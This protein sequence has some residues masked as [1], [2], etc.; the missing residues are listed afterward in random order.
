MNR[1]D[2]TTV[3]TTDDLYC[4]IATDPDVVYK[5]LA[6]AVQRVANV[7]NGAKQAVGH[8]IQGTADTMKGLFHDLLQGPL[9][10]ILYLAIVLIVIAGLLGVGFI[11]FLRITQWKR[12][13]SYQPSNTY[14]TASLAETDNDIETQ[15]QN[16]IKCQAWTPLNRI[17]G[18]KFTQTDINNPKHNYLLLHKCPQFQDNPHAALKNSA[19]G[20]WCSTK[21]MELKPNDASW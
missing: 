17:I 8:L 4:S 16:N 15:N 11:T 9:K 6:G 10:V 3:G 20:I 13:P 21:S 1:C 18:H 14:P 7:L 5:D 2:I 12:Y 19:L